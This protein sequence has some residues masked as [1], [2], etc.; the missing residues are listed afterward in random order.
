MEGKMKFTT[1]RRV[2][3]TKC[4]QEFE[5]D[6]RDDEEREE[7]LTAIEKAE[8]VSVPGGH[9]LVKECMLE[10][11]CCG[12]GHVCE[13]TK[14]GNRNPI[15]DRKK[16]SDQF[17][18]TSPSLPLSPSLSLCLVVVQEEKKKELTVELKV[19]ET[20]A[21]KR[22]LGNI[23]FIG[24]LFKLKVSSQ[25]CQLQLNHSNNPDTNG[26]EESVRISEVRG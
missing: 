5:K 17:L 21:R 6:K 16:T 19:M 7:M 10:Q 25:F 15:F 11:K 8:T 26:T 20:R 23:W 1:F 3:L 4:Q 2:L 9:L 12:M 14:L 18:C 24:E 13:K 22:S